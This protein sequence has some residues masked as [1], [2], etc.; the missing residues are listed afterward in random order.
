MNKVLLEKNY[1]VITLF[2][3]NENWHESLRNAFEIVGETVCVDR[4]YYFTIYT[5]KNDNKK[6]TSQR[7]EWAKNG[8]EP[9]ID[10][11]ELQDIPIEVVN[12]FIEPLITRG[13]FEAIV[14]K[15]SNSNTK[16]LLMA[17][18]VKSILVLPLMHKDMIIGFIGFD[19]CT[20][21]SHWSDIE[22][23]FLNSIV[24][25]FSSAIYRRNVESDLV[26]S[27]TEKNN[28]LNSIEDGF[29]SMNEQFEVIYWN[30]KAE[31]YF[32]ITA[33]YAI[34]KKIWELKTCM[35]FIRKLR[36]LLKNNLPIESFKYERNLKA[37]KMWLEVNFYYYGIS[38]SI[39]IKD[40]TNLKIQNLNLK[41][42]TKEIKKKNQEV[43]K[44][45]NSLKKI[46]WLQSHGTR[47]PLSRITGL[48]N[49][50]KE[51]LPNNERNYIIDNIISSSKEL[52]E[53]LSKIILET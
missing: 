7:Y 15:M 26:K 29:F 40:I 30:S 4:I 22:K 23:K 39:F 50:L 25:S 9:M 44:Q 36:H 34:G 32:D 24:V 14:S 13:E 49:A 20:S 48:V 8:V 53:T 1:E 16:Q 27:I 17:Q 37:K 51:E 45:N 41:K 46:A 52:D 3:K 35:V 43:L 2:L 47:A 38:S 6:Y 42:Y 21:E 12:D 11:L 5:N 31:Q 18:N 28:I 33:D 10:N 19:N